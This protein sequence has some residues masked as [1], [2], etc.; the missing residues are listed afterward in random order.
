MRIDLGVIFDIEICCQN[1]KH[2]FDVA[3]INRF[4]LSVKQN[5]KN[6]QNHPAW[7]RCSNL[8]GWLNRLFNWTLWAFSFVPM[9]LNAHIK[10]NVQLLVS[11][12]CAEIAENFM[13]LNIRTQYLVVNIGFLSKRCT[14]SFH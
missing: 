1:W 9:A 14:T 12:R 2:I 13:P 5:E 8:A 6:P 3:V 4:T 10:A 11:G 7:T